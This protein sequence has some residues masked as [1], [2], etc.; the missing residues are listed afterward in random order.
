MNLETD[1]VIIL[2]GLAF[3]GYHGVTPEEGK[4]GCRFSLDVTCGLDLRAAAA[5]DDVE[6]TISYELIFN[7]VRDSFSEKTFKLLETL[8]QHIVD[9][10]FN[11]YGDIDWIQIRVAK[12]EAPIPVVTGEFAVRLTRERPK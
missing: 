10:L 5:S 8:A 4:V 7:V 9:R 6:E 3:Y 2:K 11:A 1:D 12:P